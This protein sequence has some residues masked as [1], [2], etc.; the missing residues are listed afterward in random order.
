MRIAATPDRLYDL[1]SDVTRMGEW[2]P[3]CRGGEWLDRASGPTVGA[4][5]RGYNRMGPYRWSTTSKVVVADAGREFA[6]TV[7]AR[8][9]EA[10]RWRY[11]FQRVDDETV[12]TESYEFVWAPWYLAIGDVVMRRDRQLRKGIRST[13]ARLKTAGETG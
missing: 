8:G 12:V 11:R 6:F 9:R 5:F 2:S 13:L 7:M 1:V 3:E 4:R 10:T